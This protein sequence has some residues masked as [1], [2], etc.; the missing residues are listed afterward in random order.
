VTS[1]DV[2][3]AAGPEPVVVI[4]AGVSGCAAALAAASRGS[5]VLLLNAG[6]DSVGLPGY[7]PGLLLRPAEARSTPR[8][9]PDGD[10]HRAPDGAIPSDHRIVAWLDEAALPLERVWMATARTPMSDAPRP[11]DPALSDLLVVDRRSVSLGL[12]WLLENEPLIELRQGMV[13]AVDERPR[14]GVAGQGSTGCG[15]VARTVF[16]EEL[17]GA[18]IVLAVGLALG[19][20]IIVGERETAGGRYGEVAA[21][22]L[23]EYL[24]RKGVRFDA[25]EVEVGARIR[26]SVP[27]PTGSPDVVLTLGGNGIG[28]VRLRR[29]ALEPAQPPRP[30]DV[31]VRP[32]TRVYEPGGTCATEPPSPYDETLAAVERG[33]S[34]AYVVAESAAAESEPGDLLLPDGLVSGEWYVHPRLLSVGRHEPERDVTQLSTV[35]RPAH[36][37]RGQTIRGGEG[38]VLPG[39]W[40]AGQVAGAVGYAESLLSGWRVGVAAAEASPGVPAGGRS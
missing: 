20:R 17:H 25:V 14:D 37:I 9:D 16:G 40:A 22:E 23:C 29:V 12:K 6:L 28:G 2:S 34:F 38:Q 4:G 18:S 36:T 35:C 32:S 7:G 24:G 26:P 13:V 39:V 5:R 19:G 10:D 31:P 1:P 30:D 11:A 33:D 21:D 15:V 8:D 27:W 3:R